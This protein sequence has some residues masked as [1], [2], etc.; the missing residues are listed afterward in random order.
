M[1]KNL[2]KTEIVRLF[3]SGTNCAQ[4]VSSRYAKDLAMNMDLCM[5]LA[6]PFGGGCFRG[7]ICGAVSGALLVIGLHYGQGGPM[8]EGEDVLKEKVTTFQKIFEERTGNLI[9]RELTGY[10]FSQEGQFQQAL[11]AGV[12]YERCPVFVA[13]ALEILEDIL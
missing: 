8:Y 3:R 13:I 11:E 5:R 2:N 1:D 6:S 12:L 9:C 10:D 4:I 7:G